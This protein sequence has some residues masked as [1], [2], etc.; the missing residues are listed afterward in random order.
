MTDINLDLTNYE[1]FEDN[2]LSIDKKLTFVFGKNGTGK[3]T[4]TNLIKSQVTNFDVKCFTGFDGI[5]GNEEKLNAVILG[6]ENNEIENEIKE[7]EELIKE[8]ETK[9]IQINDEIEE[10]S[11]NKNNLYRKYIDSKELYKKQESKINKFYINS[12]KKIKNLNN[13]QIAPTTYNT[14]SFQNE[15]N[16]ANLLSQDEIDNY[17][18]IINTESKQANIV[19]FNNINLQNLLLETNKI[20]NKKVNEREVISEISGDIEKT[21]FAEKGLGIHNANDKC[22][23]CGNLISVDRYEKLQRYFSADEVEMFRKEINDHISFLKKQ[24]SNIENTSFLTDDFYPQY[25]SHVSQLSLEFKNKKLLIL[26]FIDRLIDSTDEKLKEL[27]NKSEILYLEIPDSIVHEIEKY[28]KLVYEN[29]GSDIKQKKQ[30]ARNELRYHE[31][32]K[33]L[34]DFKFEKEN[35]ELERLKIIYGEKSKLLEDEKDKINKSEI[36]INKFRNKI[37][38]LQSKTK[39][40]TILADLINKKLELYVNFQLEHFV[41]NDS[42]TGFY[43]VKDKNT[44]IYRNIIQLSSGEKN[45]IAFLYFI[46]KIDEINNSIQ[47]KEKLI[48]FDDP[49][50]SNDDTMQ[51]LIIEEL[52]SLIKKMG[53]DNKIIILTHN[54]HFYL[55]VKYNYKSYK[56]NTYLRLIS[57]GIKT[58]IKRLNSADEDFKTNYEAL[59]KE[60]EFIYEK[61]ES[62]SML[63]NPIRRIIETFTKFNLID[64]YDMLKAVPGAAKLFNVNSHSIDDLESELN[65]KSKNEIIL[66]MKE[67]FKYVGSINHFENHW[68]I[69]LEN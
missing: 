22:S 47:Y 41:E 55:N 43:R 29:N 18:K 63:L 46:H 33:C 58:N 57:N 34:N 40:E 11:H 7:L 61:A 10:S 30:E 65:G 37:L 62:E 1:I 24:K 19:T 66:M 50:T 49:M 23:F 54:N 14:N 31:I 15:I 12:A 48:V 21:E 2:K 6:E 27:F 26:S 68:K 52:D 5:V 9:I 45:V 20:L 28:N 36:Q 35:K 67:C 53:N 44:G 64:K 3:S 32:K 17:I 13:P 39:N 38:E 4:L 56:S 59:W 8:E 25:F 42:S 69:D 51:Y 60:L 16:K